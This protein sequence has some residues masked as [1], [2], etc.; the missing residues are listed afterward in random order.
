MVE[1]SDSNLI[2]SKHKAINTLLPYAIHLEQNGQHGMVNAILRA[3]RVSDFDYQNHGKFMWR[4]VQLYVSRLFEKRSPTSLNR[5][6]VLISPFVPWDHTLN[7]TT[8]VAR[9]AVAV[10]AIPYTEEVGA[11]VVDALLQIAWVD[12]LLPQIPINMWRLLKRQP[13]LPYACGGRSKGNDRDTVA[14]V[15]RLGDIDILKSYFLLIW[16]HRCTPGSKNVHAM[17]TSIRED[18]GGAGMEQHRKDLIQH[19]DRVLSRL[20]QNDRGAKKEYTRLKDVL[21]EIDRR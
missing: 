4:Q 17:E 12:F 1:A 15:R 10:S 14:Y 9:W 2:I 20:G 21:M 3:A 13:S 18:F 11:N 7:N 16:T 5:V 6:I 19:L 8:A